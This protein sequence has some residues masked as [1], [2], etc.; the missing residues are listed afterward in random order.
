MKRWLGLVFFTGLFVAILAGCGGPAPQPLTFNPAPWSDGEVSAYDLKDKNGAAAGTAS[1]TW[2]RGPD[3]GQWTQGYELNTGSRLDRG[4]VIVDAA[5]R[6]VSSWRELSGQRFATTYAADTITIIT[7]AADGKQTTKTLKPV[8]DGLDNDQTLQAQRALPLAA[9]YATRYT[10]IIPT[11]GVAAPIVLSVT[12][13]ETITVPAGTFPCWRVVMDFGSGKHDGWYGQAAPYPLVKYV[14]RASGA[15]FELRSISAGGGAPVAAASTTAPAQPARSGPLPLNVPFVLASALVQYPLMILLPI[16]LGWWLRRRYRVGWGVFLAGAG[17]FI[18]SQIV[19]LPL[20]YALGLLG[21]GRGVALWPLI[22]MAL[23]AGLSAG[24]CEEGARWLVLTFLAKKTRSWRAGLQFGAGHGGAEAIIFGL[25]ALVSFVAMIALRSLDP[26]M[27]RLA[28]AT[29]DQVQTAAAQY[30]AQ[31]WYMPIVAGLERV[32]AIT[33]QITMALLVV[34]AVA[35]KQVGYF[36]AA[37]GLHTVVDFWAVWAGSTLG[38]VWVEIGV[39]IVAVACFWLI[40]RLREEP[41]TPA[42]EPAPSPAPVPATANLAPR[43]LSAEELA[44]RAEESRYE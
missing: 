15:V 29:A 39:A 2:R 28:G 20:N 41:V 9:G 35:R 40:L 27:L 3:A 44:R 17:T 13:A 16:L 12:G 18:F 21:G 7:T 19:H 24:I 1:W 37:V 30:W 8:A 14:N 25:L 5:M 33:L 4:Q 11:S 26:A 10:D 34:R 43:T 32:F 23:V 36:L 31:P 38:M 6:P 42:A 22:P